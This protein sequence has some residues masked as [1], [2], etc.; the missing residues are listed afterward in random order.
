MISQSTTQ[1]TGTPTASGSVPSQRCNGGL[2]QGLE[3]AIRSGVIPFFQSW[4]PGYIPPGLQSSAQPDEGPA[5]TFG[6]ADGQN[7]SFFQGVE[8]G[9]RLV[10]PY[11]VL[12]A[13]IGTLLEGFVTLSAATRLRD[14]FGGLGAT[15]ASASGQ[16]RAD[17]TVDGSPTNDK[18]KKKNKPQQIPQRTSP[19]VT[20]SVRAGPLPKAAVALGT[21]SGLTAAAAT[22]P[23]DRKTE[24]W[25]AVP[26]AET[27]GKIGR[28]PNYPLNG[29]YRQTADFDGS[30]LP[31]SIGNK[32]HAFTGEYHGQ[33]HT[34]GNLR[35]CMV[36]KLAGDVDRLCF[37]NAS[38]R[39]S[40]PAGVVAC[41][42]SDGGTASN[43][44][45]ENSHVTRE[46]DGYGGTGI[47]GGDIRGTVANITAVDCSVRAKGVTGIGGGYSK[48]TVA[49]ITAMNCTVEGSYAGIGAGS[50]FHGS[51]ANT[52]AVNCKVETYEGHAGIGAG[53]LYYASAAD[54]TAMNCKVKVTALN[55]HAGIGAG[56]TYHGSVT[57]T[58]ALNC[59]VETS[60]GNAGIGAGSVYDDGNVAHTTAMDCTVKTLCGDAGIGAGTVR[61]GTV[62]NTHVFNSTIESEYGAA[63]IGGGPDSTVCNVHVNDELQPDSAGD[64]RYLLDH[65]CEDIDPRLVRANCQPGDDHFGALT[66]DTVTGFE[67]CPASG[68]TLALPTSAASPGIGATA[69]LALWASAFV[70]AGVAGVCIYRHCYRRSS[71]ADDPHRKW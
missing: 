63:S 22:S 56:L 45:V 26:D 55:G 30:R 29:T 54:T 69:D 31:H 21:L 2:W 52:T 24:R 51:V 27:L 19:S 60:R 3:V 25:I 59:K 62:A 8:L 44:R 50:V 17:I 41:E 16:S 53:L 70:L 47:V 38:I 46:G 23:S 14:L 4:H 5:F 20:T 28:D 33:C 18:S 57:D 58:A 65:F 6:S 11:T 64:C 48:G 35:Q 10:S 39:S 9:V 67:F 49:N 15:T 36:K 13:E 7:S 37:T 43:I 12:P 66:S 61:S 42:V 1:P 68:A 40:N 32:T 71:A 34:I